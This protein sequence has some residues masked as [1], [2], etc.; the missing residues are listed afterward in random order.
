M[1]DSVARGAAN[2]QTIRELL[3]DAASYK[4]FAGRPLILAA[5]DLLDNA[6]YVRV[7][8]HVDAPEDR[9]EYDAGRLLS[10]PPL[11]PDHE[12]HF[13]PEA[14][15]MVCVKCGQRAVPAD[16]APRGDA[17]SKPAPSN[18]DPWHVGQ[19]TGQGLR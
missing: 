8:V 17:E 13:D 3:E 5:I 19:S 1:S 10:D 18:T 7:P 4:A 16:P 2:P 9:Q 6:R 12:W 11:F 15:E 14:D